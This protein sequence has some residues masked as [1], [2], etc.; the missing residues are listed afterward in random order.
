MCVCIYINILELLISRKWG[1]AAG[2]QTLER[3]DWWK[4]KFALF[5][6]GGQTH[7]QRPTPRPPSPFLAWQSAGRAY[8][9]RGRGYLKEQHRLWRSSCSRSSGVCP[10]HLD[11][12]KHREAS[13]PGSVCFP[14]LR[15]VL[16]VVA[17]AIWSS[18]CSLLQSL[19]GRSQH[20]AQT[21]IHRPWGGTKVLDFA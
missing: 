19:Q 11:C 13:V 21:I 18:C 6:R 20:L 16:R 15:P 7:A 2:K 8:I 5:Q 12:L 10:G 4:G 17:A 9:G 3:Q 14:L 1:L